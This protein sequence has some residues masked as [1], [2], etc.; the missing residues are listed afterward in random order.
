MGGM[1]EFAY[2]IWPTQISRARGDLP[3]LFNSHKAMVRE[4]HARIQTLPTGASL[5]V[6]GAEVLPEDIEDFLENDVAAYRWL[7][8]TDAEWEDDRGRTLA[9][10]QFP[11]YWGVREGLDP[12]WQR[13]TFVVPQ[14]QQV[15]E[16]VNKYLQGAEAR[17][18]SGDHRGTTLDLQVGASADDGWTQYSPGSNNLG[19]PQAGPSPTN[20]LFIAGTHTSGAGISYNAFARFTGVS[21]LS[22]ATIDVS[23]ISVFGRS[24]DTG[25]AETVISADDSAS[26]ATYTTK[27]EHDGATRTT[28]GVTW[29]SPGL[30]TTTF[31]NSP[32]INT[33]IQELADSYDPSTINILH[34]DDLKTDS[35]NRMHGSSYDEDTAEAP[36]IHIESTGGGG[37]SGGQDSSILGQ[38]RASGILSA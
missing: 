24:S 26:P 31:T 28:A 25:A 12:Q 10:F 23:H 29:D 34:D 33:V 3:F 17:G 20:A 37:E 19:T 9:P 4:N 2:A 21:G 11:T 30:S 8:M 35:F 7:I 36:K 16:L 6:S 14:A 5:H 32:S 18:L 27:E 38:F 22:G 1:L 15:A 13:E